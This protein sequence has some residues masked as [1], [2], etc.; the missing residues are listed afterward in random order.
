MEL[1]LVPCM[2]GRIEQ[3]I[4]AIC[5][6][7]L[8]IWAQPAPFRFTCFVDAA[9]LAWTYAQPSILCVCHVNFW[10]MLLMHL[11]GLCIIATS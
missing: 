11:H 5:T 1:A 10:L 2:S 8:M 7:I 6:L 9:I 3:A 4:I